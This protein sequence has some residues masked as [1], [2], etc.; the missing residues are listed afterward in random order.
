MFG[1]SLSD[2]FS[3]GHWTNPCE[4]YKPVMPILPLKLPP[5]A[6]IAEH[7]SAGFELLD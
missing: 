6:M 1:Q 4:L 3:T 5:E 7:K 2:I